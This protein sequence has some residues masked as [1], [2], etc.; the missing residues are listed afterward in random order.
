MV[1]TG[2]EA[3]SDPREQ[4]EA[5]FET[6]KAFWTE[7]AEYSRYRGPYEEAVGRSAL[8]LKLLTYAP[9][10]AL[11]AAPTTSLPEEIGGGRNWDYRFCW[12]RDADLRAVRT[13]GARLQR[14]GPTLYRVP[15]PPLSARRVGD[16]DHVRHRRLAVPA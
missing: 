15:D 1:L 13:F 7:W 3:L 12:M 10:G 2:M 6:T 8:A 16:A 14:R 4:V 11:I 5:L 9:T